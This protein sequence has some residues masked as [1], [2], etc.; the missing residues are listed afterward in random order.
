MKNIPVK[1]KQGWGTIGGKKCYFR[2]KWEYDYALYLELLKKYKKITE[3]E[4]EPKT[5]WF[6]EIKRGTR[7][8][9]PDF[10]VTE[11]NGEIVWHEVKGYMDDRSKTKLKRFKKYYP[12][13]TLYL[14]QAAQIKEIR[15][16]FSFLYK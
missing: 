5:F 7:S 15:E 10:R 12:E 2:S 13:E 1:W 8:Y 9:L 3:W 14:V 6:L 11:T 16:K 4:H